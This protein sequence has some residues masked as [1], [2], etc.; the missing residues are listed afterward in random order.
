MKAIA[1]YGGSFDPP[2]KGHRLLAENLARECGAE[3]VFIIPAA[4]SPFKNGTR[5]SGED[6]LEMCRLTFDGGLFEVSDVE[7][8]RGGKSYTFDT[9]SEFR[10][11]YPDAKIY[12]FMGDDMFLC[13]DKWYKSAELLK[14]C[15]PVAACR[16]HDE[17]MLQKMR[18]Y[19]SSVPSLSDS[20]YILC[21]A[22]PFE[23]SST[24]IRE[25]LA[26]G[27]SADEFLDAGVSAFIKK[28]GLYS[29]IMNRDEE[30]TE[31]IRARLTPKRFNHSLCVAESAKE[32]ALKYGA[33]ENKAYTAGLLHDICKDTAPAEQL[34]YLLANGVVPTDLEIN[35]PKLYHAMSGA[36]YIK[37]ELGV[38]DEEIIGAVRCHTT[39]KKGMTLFDKILFIADF[40]SAD[41]DYNGVEIMRE[42]A[43]RSLDEAIIEGLS[44]TIKD[45]VENGKAVHPDTVEAFNEAVG[46]Q[47]SKVTGDR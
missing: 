36:L 26:S 27:G 5:V 33:D 2:H 46:S 4:S 12:L 22:E 30:F 9:V 39:G 47:A 23:I 31:I 15:I 38:D 40:I 34:K 44:F 13:L 21:A 41:R 1:I 18:D 17:N 8:K 43:A 37:K 24:E 45:L 25:R 28:K 42:K 32:L 16:S 35:A 3:R 10:A 29:L 7:I 14:M 20:G 11:L 6:R 19:A